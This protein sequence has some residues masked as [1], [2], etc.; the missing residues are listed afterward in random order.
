MPGHLLSV[1]AISLVREHLVL[2]L[3]SYLRHFTLELS[4]LAD[5]WAE[6][7]QFYK[8]GDLEVLQADILDLINTQDSA[9]T[10]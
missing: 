5:K 1:L 8:F 4:K 7:M 6:H 10:K 9:N 2:C 3:F